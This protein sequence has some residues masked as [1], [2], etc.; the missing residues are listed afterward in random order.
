MTTLDTPASAFA[1]LGVSPQLC[2]ALTALDITTPTEIQTRAIP[3]MLAGRDVLGRAQTG[4]GK[5]AAYG[6]P[7]LQML[8]PKDRR[9]QALVLS[10]T[11]E[12]A[13]QVTAALADLVKN[14]ADPGI[15]A[16]YGGDSMVRQF[17]A[18][19]AG[20]RVLAATPGRLIDHLNRGSVDLSGLKLIVLDEADEMLKMGFVDDVT[21]ILSHAPKERQTALFSAT[22]SQEI[23]TI[24]DNYQQAPVLIDVQSVARTASTVEQRYAVCATDERA[25]AVARLLEVEPFESALVFARTR[26]GCDQLTDELQRRGVPCEALHGDLA[27]P[28]REM[29]LRRLREGRLKVVIATDVAA[30]GL[31]VPSLDLVVTIELPGHLETYVHRIGR[32]GRA[33]RTGTSILVLGQRDE[34][35][36]RMLERFI[37]QALKYQAIPTPAEVE[38]SRLER[39]VT[40]VRERARHMDLAPWQ[41]LVERCVTD[42][43]PLELIAATL[44]QMAAPRSLTPETVML[45][46]AT[47]GYAGPQHP[48]PEGGL[49]LRPHP[50]HVEPPPTREQ[51]RSEKL[52]N[53]EKLGNPEK[54]GRDKRV[55]DMPQPGQPPRA[56][57]T[58]APRAEKLQPPREFR[59]NQ[60]PAPEAP[61]PQN[62]EIPR[63]LT[64]ANEPKGSQ[65]PKRKMVTMSLGVG[66]RN[67]VTPA[68][69]VACLQ[70]Q[71]KLPSRLLGNLEILE[72]FSRVEVP[73]EAA[74]HMA[75]VL[76]GVLVCGRYLNPRPAGEAMG[77]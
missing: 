41:R 71:A 27:Q 75:E 13:V 18:L 34:R 57:K 19:S 73:A 30:R 4:T 40:D 49:P 77:D 31:D 17:R 35:K 33:G 74:Q 38:W 7:L 16:I 59:P 23:R 14:T 6:L 70:T 28:A 58:A 15:L 47:P 55:S 61:R 37:G 12:L 2:D 66:R 5:T 69:I 67:G 32:T 76:R 24:A 53:V 39:F 56:E 11:R 62:P 68:M 60:E 48:Q 64:P 50:K 1:A 20:V 72:N 65:A 51:K 42:E 45:G 10:P 54:F 52:G 25:E 9:V 36:L 44:V 22:I 21:Q 63:G 8:D 43:L 46:T 26:A 29:V 3:E